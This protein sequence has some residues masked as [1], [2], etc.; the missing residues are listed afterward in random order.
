MSPPPFFFF[1]AHNNFIIAGDLSYTVILH[2]VAKTAKSLV[3]KKG[4]KR[5]AMEQFVILKNVVGRVANY[6]SPEN[7]T[8][9]YINF[10]HTNLDL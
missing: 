9:M 6:A 4:Q 10:A 5:D 7:K 2:T 1:E 3:S 8:C